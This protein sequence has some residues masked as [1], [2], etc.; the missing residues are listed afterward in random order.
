MA[1]DA[2]KRKDYEFLNDFWYPDVRAGARGVKFVNAC[3]KSA[4]AGSV[5]VDC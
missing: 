5:W 1:I 2:A 4:D 3:V